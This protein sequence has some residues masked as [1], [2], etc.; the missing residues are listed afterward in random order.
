[1]KNTIY[2]SCC[3]NTCSHIAIS[4]SNYITHLET[5]GIT[6]HELGMC[7]YLIICVV[8]LWACPSWASLRAEHDAISIFTLIILQGCKKNINKNTL[9]HKTK[10]VSYEKSYSWHLLTK[11]CQPTLHDPF[12]ADRHMFV[13]LTYTGRDGREGVYSMGYWWLHKVRITLATISRVATF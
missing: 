6:P 4:P 11:S 8:S 9:S 5:A 12:V 13:D 3:L 7:A 2:V 1:M 10:G